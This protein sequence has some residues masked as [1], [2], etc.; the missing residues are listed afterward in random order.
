MEGKPKDIRLKIKF[1]QE[2]DLIYGNY[3][4]NHLVRLAR[5]RIGYSKKTTGT[6]IRI[7]LNSVMENIRKGKEKFN[8][9][10]TNFFSNVKIEK[11]TLEII[12]V[13]KGIFTARIEEI[14]GAIVQGI[15]MDEVTEEIFK[16]AWLCI[17]L[18]YKNYTL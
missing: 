10:N 11:L 14:R 3:I 18:D 12:E 4:D 1:I 16:Q 15:S 6:Q 2:N 9:E 7:S 8:Q 13:P 17:K 5:K